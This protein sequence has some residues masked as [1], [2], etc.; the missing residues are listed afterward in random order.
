[1]GT[2]IH[3]ASLGLPSMMSCLNNSAKTIWNLSTNGI[4]AMSTWSYN[5]LKIIR[6]KSCIHWYYQIL[7]QYATF[8]LNHE[9]FLSSYWKCCVSH[10][11]R[12]GSVIGQK[13][14]TLQGRWKMRITELISTYKTEFT[15]QE[16]AIIKFTKSI[17]QVFKSRT[18][19]KSPL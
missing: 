17:L 3:V 8:G 12:R 11:P 7:H 2:L 14:T 9:F 18:W 15:K 13:T 4:Y 5:H 1:M 16:W 19:F 10:A 6:K